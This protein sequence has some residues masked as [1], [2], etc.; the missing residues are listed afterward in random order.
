MKFIIVY[1][2]IVSDS[3][4]Y[5]IL[6]KNTSNTIFCEIGNVIYITK[7]IEIDK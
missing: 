5:L 7:S 6:Y 1:I 3:N 4:L 2:K